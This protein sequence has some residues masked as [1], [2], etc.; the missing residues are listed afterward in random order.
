M[1][2]REFARQ[3]AEEWIEAWNSHDLEK[4]LAHYSDDF[5]MSSPR[6]ALIVGVESGIL[7]G[8]EAIGAYWKRALEL[9]PTLQLGLIT[10]F[11]GADSVV[12]CYKSVRG[13]ATEVFFFNAEGKV[14]RASANYA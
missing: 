9:T 4:I 5:V 11:V 7:E 12:L 6:I 8:K 2:T 1:L 13:L 3:F 14:V 10:F